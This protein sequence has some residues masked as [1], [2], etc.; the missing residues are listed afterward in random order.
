MDKK[1]REQIDYI[2]RTNKRLNGNKSNNDIY[3]SEA[4]KKLRSTSAYSNTHYFKEKTENIRFAN[5]NV[6]DKQKKKEVSRN[7]NVN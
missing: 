4:S 7:I 3:N 2:I 1:H 6:K 5:A